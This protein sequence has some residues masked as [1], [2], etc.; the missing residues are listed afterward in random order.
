MLDVEP[1]INT[2]E[3][4]CSFIYF[5]LC[6]SVF[7]CGSFRSCTME[8][9]EARLLIDERVHGSLNVDLSAQLDGHLK[10]CADCREDLRQLEKMRELLALTKRDTPSPKTL[11]DIWQAVAQATAE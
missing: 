10:T 7:I 8:C 3:H 11:H 2:D 5:N 6:L 1:Q 9:H 4:R